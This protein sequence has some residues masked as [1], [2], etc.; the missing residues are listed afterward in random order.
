MS[1][2]SS[3]SKRIPASPRSSKAPAAKTLPYRAI[4]PGGGRKD[5]RPGFPVVVHGPAGHMPM[6]GL[7]DSGADDALFPLVIATRIG[8]DLAKCRRESCITAGG[9]V[10]RFIWDP[11]IEIEIPDMDRRRDS[12]VLLGRAAF[13]DRSARPQRLLLDVQGLCRRAREDLPIRQDGAVAPT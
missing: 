1:K 3:K 12:R 4:A 7:I 9:T 11:G 2:R 5:L 10:N 6:F 13:A 8:I